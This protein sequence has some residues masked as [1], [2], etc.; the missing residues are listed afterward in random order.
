MKKK[1]YRPVLYYFGVVLL[2]LI[3]I[4]PRF[5]VYYLALF[6]GY[7]AFYLNVRERKKAICNLQFAFGGTKNQTEIKNI[8]KGVFKNLAVTACDFALFPKLTLEKIR[9]IT[10]FQSVEILDDLVNAQGKG[11]IVLSAHI[12]NWELLAAALVAL[13]FDGSVLATEIYYPKYDKLINSLRLSRGVKTFYRDK[14]PRELLRKLKAKGIVGVV[15]DL[16]IDGLDGI[17]VDFFDKPSFTPTG[18]AK[19]AV[20]TQVPIVPAFMIREGKRYRLV[21]EK[22][23][24]TAKMS[25]EP[26]ED[27]I[28]RITSE[29]CKVVESYIKAYPDQWGWM[30]NRWKTKK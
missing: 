28:K 30:H 13:G 23:I 19:L 27:A 7:I 6:F 20:K 1:W 12:G 15:P 14:S 18:P 17:F 25:D 29:W 8:A 2:K 9:K 5:A 22:V 10:T 16:D 26:D 24:D 21:V 3:L 4:L 11:L